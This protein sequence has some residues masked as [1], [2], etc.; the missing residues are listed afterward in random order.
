M[1]GP[2]FR[3]PVFRILAPP[4]IACAALAA[5]ALPAGAGGATGHATEWTQLLN[6]AELGRILDIE[7]R[8]LS[9]ETR[10]LSAELRQVRTQLQ[11]LD[12]MR[13]NIERLPDRHL[14]DVLEPA[15]RLARIAGEA[16]SVARSGARIDGFLRSD[17]ITDPLFERRGL[18]RARSGESYEAWNERWHAA[19]ETNLRQTGLTFED[20]ET[21]ARLIEAIQ[22]RFGDE[23]G[24][25][26]VLQGTNEIASSLARQMNDLR[27]ITA[28]Q[29]EEVSIAWARVLADMDER[30]ANERAY[31]REIGETIRSLEAAPG[32][33]TLN[34]LFGVSR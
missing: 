20:V 23:E 12:I 16:G 18:D 32:G 34:E 14:G 29:S 27:R 31:E 30:E 6:N 13:R 15:L 19:M 7:T 17:L 9:T 33:R 22:S 11:A 5:G 8:S 3:A 24:Q 28:T 21:E 1:N 2:V 26:Q 10:S 4:L 25:M